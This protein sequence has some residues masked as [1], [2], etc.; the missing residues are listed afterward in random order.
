MLFCTYIY[1]SLKDTF[2]F[3]H[4]TFVSYWFLF[5]HNVLRLMQIKQYQIK[6]KFYLRNFCPKSELSIFQ[7][8]FR[9]CKLAQQHTKSPFP[10]TWFNHVI[11]S[12]EIGSA[13]LRCPCFANWFRFIGGSV[14]KRVWLN[15]VSFEKNIA[16]FCY[17]IFLSF[18]AY[19]LLFVLVML[20]NSFRL[21]IP[22]LLSNI[23][24]FG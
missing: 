21:L 14:W 12:K 11:G 1:L 18:V 7:N 10:I 9:F 22:I 4:D 8:C 20:L 23:D 13:I 24:I 19:F 6:K 2:F 15:M 17:V 3:L 16:G 5:Y